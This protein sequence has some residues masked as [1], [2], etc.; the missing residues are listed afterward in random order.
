MLMLS[1]PL[2]G[3][4]SKSTSLS[5]EFC[6]HRPR[7][8]G[9]ICLEVG[10]DFCILCFFLVDCFGQMESINVNGVLQEAGDADS[11]VRI[12]SQV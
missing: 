7:Q 1:L 3:L 10:F 9:T 6:V 11:S 12:R 4:G 8:Y 2:L 5:L